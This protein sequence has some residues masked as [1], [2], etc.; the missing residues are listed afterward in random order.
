MIRHLIVG[1]DPGTTCAV[2]AVDL[3]GTIVGV[4]SS[5][6]LGMSQV[7]NYIISLG[8]PSIIAS[9]VC[10]APDFVAGIATSFGVGLFCPKTSLSVNE[11]LTIT[12]PFEPQDA[13]QRDALAAALNAY[14][15]FQK[16]LSKMDAQGLPDQV[17]HVVLQG[18]SIARAR[19]ELQEPQ[20]MEKQ[21]PPVAAHDEHIP[22]A[23]EQRI[24]E[25]EKRVR[26]LQEVIIEKDH[27]IVA[28]K[29]EIAKI[30]RVKHTSAPVK[31]QP[32]KTLVQLNHRIHELKSIETLLRRALSGDVALVG[33]Y[34]HI[35]D[36]LTFIEVRPETTKG[37][38]IAFTSD[39]RVR[40]YLTEQGI[41]VFSSAELQMEGD[42]RYILRKRLQELSKP[43][44]RETDL[45]RIVSEYR[46]RKA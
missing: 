44:T 1:V 39:G 46:Q 33:H 45:M 3:Q 42:Y 6:D 41:E 16:K 8:K 9:D 22:T 34:P 15:A 21:S 43:K 36:G 10:P 38:R 2:A 11:K 23:E 29:D 14:T 4:H 24:R 26:A 37:I 19:N 31:P 12:R 35:Q 40:E 5:K 18:K 20:S 7:V 32:D 25:L 17:K 30:R 27:A 28:L 13:H